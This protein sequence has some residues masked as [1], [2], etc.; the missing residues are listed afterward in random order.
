[1]GISQLAPVVVRRLP[2]LKSHEE[3]F[4]MSNTPKDKP[5]LGGIPL[6]DGYMPN[7]RPEP[8]K[9]EGLATNGYQPPRGSGVSPT[10][11]PPKKP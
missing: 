7:P 3:A 5:L 11:P 4:S 2:P 8:S 9:N 1:M 10:Q 6:R